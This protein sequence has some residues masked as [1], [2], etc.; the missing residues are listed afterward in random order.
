M[1]NDDDDDEKPSR[2]RVV[3][4]NPNARSD[5]K[6]NWAKNEAQRTLAVFA[7]ALLRVMAGSATESTYLMRHLSEFIDA[8]KELNKSS[9]QWLTIN[10]LEE[11]LLLPRADR[12]FARSDDWAHREW[13]REHGLDLI[14]QGAL[15]LAAHKILNERPHFGGKYSEDVIDAGIRTLEELR[16]PPPRSSLQS[17]KPNLAAGW[18]DVDLGPP[19]IP[20]RRLDERL[21]TAI[22]SSQRKE[23]S[24]SAAGFNHADLKELRKAIK[25]KDNKRIAELTAKI[26][27]PAFEDP[28]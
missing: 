25:A 11:A 1:S 23:V 21:A 15:R 10:E 12:D 7:S 27:R 16:R 8:Q 18:D 20:K 4:D 24:R 28:K 6:M 17:R 5:R 2:L 22:D 3:S 26:G 13:L 19:E 14:L 9:G